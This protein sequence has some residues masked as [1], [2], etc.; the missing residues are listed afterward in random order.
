MAE[1]AEFP[2]ISINPSDVCQAGIGVLCLIKGLSAGQACVRVVASQSEGARRMKQYFEIAA[3]D[4][5]GYPW[6]LRL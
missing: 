2:R 4:E 1:K 6:F 5:G 3:L